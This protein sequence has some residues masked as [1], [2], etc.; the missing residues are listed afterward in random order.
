MAENKNVKIFHSIR[1]VYQNFGEIPKVDLEIDL[2]NEYNIYKYKDDNIIKKLK[3]III[4]K[5]E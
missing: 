5:L 4:S 1:G 3:N 2:D